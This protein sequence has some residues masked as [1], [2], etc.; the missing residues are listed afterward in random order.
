MRASLLIASLALASAA[1]MEMLRP[2]PV[3][4]LRGGM[5]Q[6]RQ[7]APP[8]GILATKEQVRHAARDRCHR[9]CS[10]CPPAA[11][12]LAR[13]LGL[14]AHA[15]PTQVAAFAKR[16][17]Y[18]LATIYYR[19]M[20]WLM[21]DEHPLQ[22]FF[23]SKQKVS[24]KAQPADKGKETVRE[25]QQIVK[26]GLLGRIAA[27][28]LAIV[29]LRNKLLFH[30]GKLTMAAGWGLRTHRRVVAEECSERAYVP[31]LLAAAYAMLITLGEPSARE[32]KRTGRMLFENL[33]D[34]SFYPQRYQAL[35]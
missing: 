34:R 7:P 6:N 31:P 14:S 18:G 10:A 4:R 2:A 13:R 8:Q 24:R 11:A 27:D 35:K 33:L 21:I 17:G 5:R 3:L 26:A 32:Y 23:G 1:S 29:G 15:S 9:S 19:P 16:V 22:W 28:L 30:G 20:W 25:I 12:V